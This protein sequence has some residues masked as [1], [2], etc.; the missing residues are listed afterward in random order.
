[1][2]AGADAVAA[3]V[4]AGLRTRRF[5]RPLVVRDRVTSTNDLARALAAGG[6]GEG[7]VAMALEQT[8]GRGRLGRPWRSPRGGLYLSV[9]L[10]PALDPARWPV[11]GLA[12]SVGA[13]VAAETLAGTLVDV[14]WPNDLVVGTGKVGGILVEAAG[15][16]AVCGIG[17]N[18]APPPAEAPPAEPVGWL[19]MYDPRVSI[20]ALAPA[21]LL[22]CERRYRRLQDNPGAVLAEWRIRS[23]TLGRRVQVSGAVPVEGTAEDIDEDGALLVRTAGGLRRV[24]AG[25]VVHLTVSSGQRTATTGPGWPAQPGH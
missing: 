25:D 10:R 5:G 6:A 9:V 21:V 7:A 11:L 17:I 8:A 2:S 23:S 19:A 12:M 18:V 22:E 14:K 15:E 3:V 16:A 13:A 1:M 24:L 20:T 4:G